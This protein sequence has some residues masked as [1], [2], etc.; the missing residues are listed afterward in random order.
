MIEVPLANRPEVA[1]IDDDDAHLVLSRRWRWAKGYA[2]SGRNSVSMHRLILGAGRSQ[3]VDHR[4]RDRLDNRREN[5]RLA[6]KAENA[7]N[8]NIRGGSSRYRGVCWDVGAHTNPKRRWRA[9]IRVDGHVRFLGNFATEEEAA[10]AWN[11]AAAVI[12]PDFVLL[13]ETPR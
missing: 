5:L 12:W 8:G 10:L 9:S 6:T 13:N 4:N 3:L 7:L 1:L 11:A 2:V